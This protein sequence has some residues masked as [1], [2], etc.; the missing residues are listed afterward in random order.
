MLEFYL[1]KFEVK[2]EMWLMF[3]QLISSIT[4]RVISSRY[5]N[6]LLFVLMVIIGLMVWSYGNNNLVIRFLFIRSSSRILNN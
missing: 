5:Y 6:S 4:R 2:A 1:S 3:T